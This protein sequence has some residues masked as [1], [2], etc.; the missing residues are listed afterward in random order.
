VHCLSAS[1]RGGC[2]GAHG[3]TGNGAVRAC[4]VVRRRDLDFVADLKRQEGERPSVHKAKRI[5]RAER[6]G[7]ALVNYQMGVVLG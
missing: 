2:K 5:F 6:A 4:A 7:E 1:A 3:K